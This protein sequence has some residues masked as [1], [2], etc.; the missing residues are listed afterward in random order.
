MLYK[1]NSLETIDDSC[2]MPIDMHSKHK[3][4]GI[5]LILTH[6]HSGAKFSNKIYE[7]LDGLHGVGI[8]IVNALSKKLIVQVKKEGKIYQMDFHMARKHQN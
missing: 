4:S 5:E 2:G 6:L 1:D 3:V 8:S 7:Y